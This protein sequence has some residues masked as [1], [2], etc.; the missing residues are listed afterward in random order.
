[1]AQVALDLL[2]P[3]PFEDQELHVELDVVPGDARGV[4]LGVNLAPADVAGQAP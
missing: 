4:S 3:R 1:M 2:S